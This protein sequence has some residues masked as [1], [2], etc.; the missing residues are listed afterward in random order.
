MMQ[1]VYIR[2]KKWRD[3]CLLISK[4]V[5]SDSERI[6]FKAFYINIGDGNGGWFI[7]SNP[8]KEKLTWKDYNDNYESIPSLLTYKPKRLPVQYSK[9]KQWQT[10][11]RYINDSKSR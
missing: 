1:D 8:H 4:V 3:I 11:E 9:R 2:H 6:R 7:H 5:Y 10:L